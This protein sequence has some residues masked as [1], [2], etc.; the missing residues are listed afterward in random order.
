ME[1][2]PRNAAFKLTT[3]S[4]ELVP[5]AT[6]VSPTTMGGI[7]TFSAS[8]EAPRISPS[9]PAKSETNPKTRKRKTSNDIIIYERLIELFDK[10]DFII[11]PN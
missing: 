7:P 8:A 4:G 1:L 5:N 3:S 11:S 9:A 10:I 6:T 2:L